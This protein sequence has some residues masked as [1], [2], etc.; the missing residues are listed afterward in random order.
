VGQAVVLVIK[1]NE[2]EIN[3]AANTVSSHPGV[4]MGAAFQNFLDDDGEERLKKFI[5]VLASQPKA[6]DTISVFH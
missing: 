1:A 4:G 2:S 5:S 3:V 6:A